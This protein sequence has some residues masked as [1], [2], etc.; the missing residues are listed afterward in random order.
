M[1]TYPEIDPILFQVGPLKVH[2]YGFMYL[3]GFGFAWWLGSRR[4]RE[5]NAIVTAQQLSDLIFYGAL[6]V[7]LGGRL[8]YILFYDLQTYMTTPW[9]IFKVWQGGMSFHGGFIG[10]LVAMGLY[11]RQINRRFF[12][13][14]DF[15][16][17]LIPLGLGAGRMGNFINGELWGRPTDLPWGMVF[18]YADNLPRHPSQLYQMALEGI[19]LFIILWLFSKRPRPIMAV[20][21]L[22]LIGYGSFRFLVEFVRTPDNHLGFIAFDWMT[23]GQLLTLPM[24][25]AG[26]ILMGLAYSRNRQLKT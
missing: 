9:A 16:A 15:I 22:F 6:G 21:G 17:P 13:V 5:P 23:M 2:W 25:I 19:V 7:V 20:S 24:L 18:P 1:L 3:I 12:E 14:T 11:A 10:V 4:T 8:G 26:F